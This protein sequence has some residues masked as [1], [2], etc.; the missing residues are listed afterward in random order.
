MTSKYFEAVRLERLTKEPH[1][2]GIAALRH[3]EK[4]QFLSYNFYWQ[5]RLVYRDA[6]KV[7]IMPYQGF[8][9][10]AS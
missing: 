4:P 8:I 2:I 7:K 3:S 10:Y 5:D 1:E 9:S 6:S